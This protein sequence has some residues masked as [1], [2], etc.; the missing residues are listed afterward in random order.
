MANAQ[1][2]TELRDDWRKLQQQLEGFSPGFMIP[3]VLIVVV[4]LFLWSSWYTVQPEETAVVQRFGRVH[5]STGP[6]LHFK[7]PLGIETV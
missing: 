3:V 7:I 1:W 6:G 5:R 2:P 4:L